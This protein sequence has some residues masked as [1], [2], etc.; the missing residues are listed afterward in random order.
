MSSFSPMAAGF[1]HRNTAVEVS[2]GSWAR[3]IQVNTGGASCK[4]SLMVQTR[5]LNQGW[6]Q[7]H[8]QL[9]GPWLFACTLD[10]AGPPHRCVLAVETGHGEQVGGK[11]VDSWAG[12][13]CR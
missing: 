7:A 4:V 10:A 3:G 6:G 11:Q 2:V 9:H 8:K 12:V 5:N 1:Q 13:S